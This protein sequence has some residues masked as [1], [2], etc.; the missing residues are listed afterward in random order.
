[1]V[2][3]TSQVFDQLA[4][5]ESDLRSLITNFNVTAGAFADESQNLE[6]TLSELA[7]FAEDSQEQLA[8]INTTFPPL[9]A[10]ARALT[11]GVKE[12][13]ATIRAGNPWLDQTRLLLRKN[14][15]GSLVNNLRIATPQLA[16]GTNSLNGLLSQ[17]ELTSD[18][19]TNVLVPTGD[20]VINDQFGTGATNYQEFFYGVAAQAGEGANFDGNGSYLRIQPAGG[21][22]QVSTPVPGGNPGLPGITGPDNVLYGNTV[23]PPVGTQPLK[24]SKK[25][26]VKTDQACY[27]QDVSDLNGP[28][29]GIG[30]PNPAV[31]GG[32]NAVIP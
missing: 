32:Q 14:E 23:T 29:G 30:G 13:P 18:C 19:V 28:L 9:R 15:L 4:S 5:R 12:L 11:P 2:N 27:K 8:R 22:L 21:N 20:V 10:F 31:D 16:S 17:L 7:P 6:A 3:A 24:P 26:P 1:M 25:P